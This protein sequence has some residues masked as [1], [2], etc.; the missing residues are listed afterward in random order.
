MSDF[1][2]QHHC[3]RLRTTINKLLMIQHN[4][5]IRVYYNS[6]SNK[7]LIAKKLFFFELIH[8][9][10]HFIFLFLCIYNQWEK[11]SKCYCAQVSV[12]SVKCKCVL[13]FRPL[14]GR[15][16]SNIIWIW[17]TTVKLTKPWPR[18]RTRAC[19]HTQTHIYRMKEQ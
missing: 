3:G 16:Y 18:T 9:P 5:T 15:E 12:Y 10:T 1:S 17:D 13:L 8:F 11:M 2:L 14:C 4:L 19:T 6:D 7:H